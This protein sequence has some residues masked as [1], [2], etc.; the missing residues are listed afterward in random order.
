M[1]EHQLFA[2]LFPVERQDSYNFFEKDLPI[3]SGKSIIAE[4]DYRK[5]EKLL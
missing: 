1:G 2:L 5:Y 3:F 4:R